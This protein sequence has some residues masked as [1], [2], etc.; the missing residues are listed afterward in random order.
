VDRKREE[1]HARAVSRRSVST[2]P[3]A[4]LIRA[5]VAVRHE[6]LQHEQR[7]RAEGETAH[8]FADPCALER[9]NEQGERRGGQHDAGCETEHDVEQSA[10][11]TPHEQ[12]EQPA[13]AVAQT[14]PED[15][16]EGL[17]VHATDT[18]GTR[19]RGGRQPH[20]AFSMWP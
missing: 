11:R 6:P 18:L 4:A 3:V 20:M 13:H 5:P 1:Q 9:A 12:Q 15:P 10:R 19:V 7:C 2:G 16:R 8:H 14:T 17:G